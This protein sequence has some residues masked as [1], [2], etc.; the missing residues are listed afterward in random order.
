[1][2]G[3]LQ[4]ELKKH[5]KLWSKPSLSDKPSSCRRSGGARRRASASWACRAGCTTCP[6][7]SRRARRTAAARR[8]T[9]SATDPLPTGRA[10]GCQP[11]W[12]G[13]C[14]GGSHYWGH[15]KGHKAHNGGKIY[16]CGACNQVLKQKLSPTEQIQQ[17]TAAE[18]AR[19]HQDI[20]AMNDDEFNKW[21]TGRG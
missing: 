1:M 8:S 12:C 10:A 7:S 21:S 9:R 2:R 11:Q 15:G 3:L 14:C 4:E 16:K 13:P 18:E 19:L 17:K 5:A 6:P 20:G